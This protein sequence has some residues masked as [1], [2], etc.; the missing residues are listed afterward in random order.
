MRHLGSRRRPGIGLGKIVFLAC[1]GLV[2]GAGCVLQPFTGT[3]HEG[4]TVGYEMKFSGR[5]DTPSASTSA[6]RALVLDPADGDPILGSYTQIGQT[7]VSGPPQNGN[8][9]FVPFFDWEIQADGLSE[10]QWPLGGLARFRV[11]SRYDGASVER[12]MATFN[13]EGMA[14]LDAAQGLAWRQAGDQ[15]RSQYED[16][17]IITVV[18]TRITPAEAQD[19][20][21]RYLGKGGNHDSYSSI[22]SDHV[23]ETLNYYDTILAPKT[24]ADFITKYEFPL[25]ETRAIYYNNGDL[26]IAR[27]MHCKTFTPPA[28][29]DPVTACYVTNYGRDGNN[30]VVFGDLDAQDM[31]NE[32]QSPVHVAGTKNQA[33]ATVAMVHDPSFPENSVQFMVYDQNGERAEY[34]AL[35][36]QGVIAAQNDALPSNAN[37][38]VPDNCLACHGAKADYQRKESGPATITDAA[39]LPFDPEA[40]VFSTSDPAYSEVNMAPK[41]KALNAM[42][43]DTKP[44]KAVRTLLEGM[45]PYHGTPVGPKD[46]NSAFS[47]LYVPDGWLV[48][49]KPGKEVYQE[50]IKPYCRSCHVTASD[51]KDWD[52]FAELDFYRMDL[53]ADVCEGGPPMPNAQQAQ[54]RFWQSSARAYLVNAFNIGSACAP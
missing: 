34:A 11:K 20:K 38:N 32:A 25:G 22:P 50:V 3:I 28:P 6:V 19:G 24:L 17:T 41:I 23:N 2:V 51:F 37:I 54:T 36:N 16:D 48:A 18:S 31:I 26:G 46:P 39:F 12:D 30:Q 15:C 47:P 9:P 45:Y 13:E 49:G 4:A 29:A 5:T 35:D 14:C 27:D 42:V 43:W 1:G 44:P 33:V 52:S 10:A 53:A 7:S 21:V 8:D 40:F